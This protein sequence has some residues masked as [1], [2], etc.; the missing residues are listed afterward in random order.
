MFIYKLAMGS[1]WHVGT[2]PYKRKSYVEDAHGNEQI[3]Y[4]LTQ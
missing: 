3:K 1:Y 2:S 4:N